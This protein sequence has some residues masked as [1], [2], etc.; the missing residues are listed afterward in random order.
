ME[1]LKILTKINFSVD[2][3]CFSH[4]SDNSTPFA[5]LND[6]K[7]SSGFVAHE[8]KFDLRQV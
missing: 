8:E 5:E 6:P 1:Q 7:N 4:I 2:L 3:K